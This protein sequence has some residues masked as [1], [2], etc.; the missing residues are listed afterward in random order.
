MEPTVT[1]H[2]PGV[3]LD[4][5]GLTVTM[6]PVCHEPIEPAVGY[7]FEYRD[8]VVVVSGDT[9]VCP[10]YAAGAVGADLLVSE[11]ETGRLSCAIALSEQVANRRQLNNQEVKGIS[12]EASLPNADGQEVG[13]KKLAL[14]HL[15]PSCTHIRRGAVHPRN[16]RYY[17]ARSSSAATAWKCPRRLKKRFGLQVSVEFQFV[18][19]SST[20]LFRIGQLPATLPGTLARANHPESA[21]LR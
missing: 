1:E 6:F 12:R 20:W 5:D 10:E 18:A 3:V 19:L 9:R 17:A 2:E 7:R 21:C 8:Q 15:F 13:V 11:V 4:E 14:T 16:E